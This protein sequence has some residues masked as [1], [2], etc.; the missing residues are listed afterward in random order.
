MRGPTWLEARLLGLV[1]TAHK[2]HE[3][4]HDVAV[5]IRWPERVL[6]DRP[7]WRED[8]KVGDRDTRHGGGA[9]EHREDAWV[10]VVKAD[11]VHRAELVQ[12]VLERHTVAVPRHD[13]ES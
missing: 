2:A 6:R 8:D 13:V 12:V 11:G 7:P 4:V 3:L 1:H 5:E 9:G 10:S